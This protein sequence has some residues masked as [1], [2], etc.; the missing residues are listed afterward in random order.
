ML[1]GFQLNDI[2]GS[3]LHD[4]SIPGSGAIGVLGKQDD[5]DAKMGARKEE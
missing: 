1:V 4:V 5:A 2:R 3:G